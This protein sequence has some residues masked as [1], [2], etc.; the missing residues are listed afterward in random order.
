[1]SLYADSA[2]LR[3]Y[4]PEGVEVCWHLTIAVPPQAIAELPALLASAG[5]FSREPDEAVA[6]IVG[7]GDPC[8][9][10]GAGCACSLYRTRASD[11]ER[12][13]RKAARA[14]W[15]PAKLARALAEADDW[16]GLALSVRDAVASVAERWGRAAIY[17]FWD[18]KGGSSGVSSPVAVGPT[19]LRADS[20]VVVEGRLVA[21]SAFQ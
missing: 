4:P 11:A 20:T 7:R 2:W 5:G 9:A 1:M 14:G 15:S 6:R 17:L 18:G 21:V 13:R 10:V 12:I 3:R 19:R 8:F 16:S